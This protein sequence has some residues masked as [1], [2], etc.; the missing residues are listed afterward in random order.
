MGKKSKAI[1]TLEPLELPKNIAMDYAEQANNWTIHTPVSVVCT[2]KKESNENI[3]QILSSARSR[4]NIQEHK[5]MS[6]RAAAY[7][8][9]AP[10]LLIYLLIT[11]PA[12]EILSLKPSYECCAD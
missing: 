1:S 4:S 5:F 10:F 6:I 3:Q 12:V 2:L 7:A 9:E 8:I 11:H